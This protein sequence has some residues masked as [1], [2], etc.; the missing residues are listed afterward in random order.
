MIGLP[1]ILILLV[2]VLVVVGYKRLPQFGRSSGKGLRSAGESARE[3]STTVGD[4]FD[5]KVAA[6]VDPAE[7]GRTAGRGVR[8]ARELKAAL[9]S[10]PEGEPEA[11]RSTE[12]EEASTAEAS[13]EDQKSTAPTPQQS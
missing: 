4:K 9:T 7:I 13:D 1:E 8:E 10:L 11:E 3:L 5:E 6:A 12:P 2:I